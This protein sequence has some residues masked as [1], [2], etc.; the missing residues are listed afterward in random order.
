M[1]EQR[2][3]RGNR[4]NG[5]V[6]SVKPALI[7]LAC[8][9]IFGIGIGVALFGGVKDNQQLMSQNVTKADATV[10]T[11]EVDTTG[12]VSGQ[13][14]GISGQ[15][16]VNNTLVLN[17]S[18]QPT[19][20]V[21][22]QIYYDESANEVRYYD[23]TSFQGLAT[24]GDLAEALSQQ[25]AVQNR[26]QTVTNLTQQFL[27]QQTIN[28]YGAA[29][30]A[31]IQTDN[32][33]F[34]GTNTFTGANT[35]ADVSVQGFSASGAAS[36][37]GSLSVTGS[38]VLGATNAS[39]LLLSSALGVSSGGT[40]RSSFNA[41]EIVIGQGSGALST[42][43]NGVPGLCLI[44]TAGAPSFQTC[45]GGAGSAGVGSLNG[46]TGDLTI[47]NSSV[48]GSTI[49]I[50]SATTTS[51]GLASFNATNLSVT[52]GNV[53]TIQDIAVSA[54]PTFG[55]LT[56]NGTINGQSISS[57]ANFTGTLSVAGVITANTITPNG[58][59]VIGS[60]GQS[61]TLQGSAGTSLSATSG[62]N[63]TTL[64]FASPTA[65]VTYRLQSAAA[66]TYNVC[67]SAGNCVGLGGGVTTSGGTAGA[68]ARF[69]GSQ[70]LVDSI[71]SESGSTITVN[72]SLAVN[73]ITPTAALTVG[74]AV[75]SLVLQGDSSTR[76]T[77]QLGGITNSLL[78]SAPSGSNKSIVLPNA[79]GTVAVSASGPL[80][81]DA[82]GNISCATCTT[83]GGGAGGAV[84]SINGINGAVL[85]N[86]SSVA[87]STITI[88]DA[89]T[90]T[91]G[92]AS[93]NS[94]NFSVANGAVNTIQD[95]GVSST[96]TFNALTLNTPLGISSG[97]TGASTAAG[98]RTNLGA[99]ASG[100]NTDITSLGGLSTALS[101]SQGGT[102]ATSSQSAING[103]SQLTTQGDLLF[104]DGSNST[105][106]ARGSSGQCLT[107]STNSIAWSSCGP[108]EADTLATVTARGATTNTALF[109]QG[110]AT[111]RGLTIDTSSSTDD[112]I[113]LSVTSGG[114]S[115]FT[116]QIT[117][118]DLTA[119]RTWTLPDA[120]GTICLQGSSSCGFLT[121]S[122]SNYIQNQNASQ[123]AT[124]D[125]WISGTGRADIA[126]QAPSFDTATSTALN[127]GS[128]NASVLNL[129]QNTV[130]AASKS[131]TI[132]GGATGTRPAAPSEGM[133]YYDM[134]TKQLLVY[135]NGKWQ[136]DRTDSSVIVAANDS[137]NKEGADF[138]VSSADETAGN[139][140]ATITTAIASLPTSGGT[141]YLMEGTYTV[142]SGILLPSKT[143][144]A[145]AGSNSTIIKLKNAHNGTINVIDSNSSTKSNIKVQDLR[146]DGN[147]ANQTAGTQSGIYVS[148]VGDGTGASATA[149]MVIR[150]VDIIN[151]R[152]YGLDVYDSENGR[153]ENVRAMGN[154]S[155]GVYIHW[156][157]F[158]NVFTG[159]E[160]SGNGA[161]GFRLDGGRYNK[162]TSSK[163][164]SNGTGGARVE[165]TNTSE[166]SFEGNTAQ[167]NTG[168]GFDI[169]YG[170][171]GTYANN[172]IS[173]NSSGG[174]RL[175]MGIN[176][177]YTGALIAD[178]TIFSNTG[179]GIEADRDVANATISGNRLYSNTGYGISLAGYL[180]VENP[181]NNAI[182]GNYVYSNALGGINLDQ[183]DDTVVEGNN[184][185]EN[186]G[187]TTNNGIRLVGSNSSNNSINDNVITDASCT[188]N[189]YA[190]LV[191]SAANTTLSN[192]TLGNGTISD[193]GVG[194][195]YVNQTDASGNLI[196]RGKSALAVNTSTVS[197]SFT[198][199]GGMT[200]VQL[201]TPA[202]PSVSRVGTS[203]TSTYGY[204][205][206]AL[207]GT[208][209]T[210]ASTET[211]ITNGNA[212][213][214][215]TNYNSI[216]WTAVPGAVQYR[217]YRTTTNGTPATTGLIATTT[218]GNVTSLN[219]TGLAATTA[220]PTANTTGGLNV[221]SNIQGQNATL[222]G[223]TLTMG[224]TSQAGSLVISDGSSNTATIQV[225]NLAGNYTYSL[226]VVTANDTFCMLLAANCSG[227]GVTTVGA[228]DGG[229]ANANGATISSSTI[230]L[231]SA[232][233]T[234]PGLVNTTTQTFAGDKTFSGILSVQDLTVGAGKSITV[235][236]GITGTR[237]GTPV[238]GMVYFDTTTKQLLTYSNGKWQASRSSST[239]VVAASNSSQAAKD[240]AD[241]VATGTADQT[242]INSALTAAAGGTVL[243]MPGT[244]YQ[245]G[246]VSV[247]NNTI[248]S[249]SGMNT[250]L[251]MANAT[252]GIFSMIVN[253]DT[254]TGTNV[255]VRDLQIDGNRA[256][257][258]SGSNNGINFS[259]MGAG[260]GAAARPG[261]KITNVIVKNMRQD[262]GIIIGGSNNIVSGST[263][264]NNEI[265]G[266][267][268]AGSYNVVTGNT[269]HGN[270]N[271][272][273]TMTGS[274]NTVSNNAVENGGSY[275]IQ[276]VATYSTISG[277]TLNANGSA[278]IYVAG[279]H[280]T[281]TGNTSST[282]GIGIQVVADYATL[283]GNTVSG[284]TGNGI[285]VQANQAVIS[286]NNVDNN[287]QA[288]IMLYDDYS[289]VASNR[290]HNNGG[291]G[292]YC[293]ATCNYNSIVGNYITDTAG[294]SYAIELRSFSGTPVGNYLSNNQFS[295]NGAS[296]ISDE[297][298]DTVYSNQ[299]DG[300]GNTINRT[301]GG[302]LTI[303]TATASAS[304]TLQGGMVSGQ[305]TAPT[306]SATVTNVGTAGTTTYRYQVTAIDG[307]GE[308]VGSTI[309]QT[310]TG[311]AT[312]TTSNYNTI[313]WTAVP[314]AV[315]YGIYK[316]SGAACT[317]LKKT[318]V[319]G[320]ATSFNDQSAG[321]PVGAAPVS[322][323]T[324][325]ITIAG[326][327]QGSSA[328]L[329]GGLSVAGA[330]TL[331][332][333]LTAS[334]TALFKNAS[335]SNNAFQIQNSSSVALF[336]ADTSATKIVIRT[337]DISYNLTV[338]GHIITGGSTPTIAANAAACTS[339]TVSVS[340]TDTAGSITVT[341]GTGCAGGG[342]LATVTFAGAFG[343]TPKI[344][345][346][347]ASAAAAGLN[348]YQDDASLTTG[349]FSV[350]VVGTPADTTTYK[351]HYYALQ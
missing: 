143:I 74:S 15:L 3:E 240:A 301:P 57:N 322:N 59:M 273:I 289:Q 338:N 102:G 172:Y 189:C 69:N 26:P 150:D 19:Q 54:A 4:L 314:G 152:T 10:K 312:L 233:G 202:A 177:S 2:S 341:T 49:T 149:G 196:N 62:A 350:G 162:V 64:D 311:N 346:T 155:S 56:V 297:G 278:N 48:L 99:A 256:N 120:S 302:G 17:P 190:I 166:N 267:N 27:T 116:G 239:K 148:R 179:H 22:G 142:D 86:N 291:N 328:S 78:F 335:D 176:P 147:K 98:A 331:S 276:M 133:V 211:T 332:G 264:I 229:T 151:F 275:G 185:A 206:S 306:L 174:I 228:L 305:L 131:L 165:A 5:Q 104:H 108:G 349:A 221:V 159:I 288:G 138:V 128:T 38:S 164:N 135:A 103:L 226:P 76:L 237:P 21:A 153:Y 40:G 266:L 111:S 46:Q 212:T 234:S 89:S 325:G 262:R 298:T 75:Q 247:P 158:H 281:V 118:T 115:R 318:T 235:T 242:Q 283:T 9:G 308:T 184:V 144:L 250:V 220:V 257:Q 249:G 225:G 127:I 198:L 18:G 33:T 304:L 219:D 195:M 117:A 272:T 61:L 321:T 279:V 28:N 94:S 284:N 223:G 181:D 180:S 154:T 323:T 122:A 146:V 244:Y 282:S 7:S 13:S 263:I 207:D 20:T 73:T 171:A 337:L 91:K 238:E 227:G 43:A 252:N 29:E 343:A 137:R 85:L 245:T 270:Q 58:S 222:T 324:G 163:F 11:F 232:S 97:G 12:I 236:G 213:L 255:A 119:N 114:A 200:N 299:K 140:D 121:G 201:P 90:S 261:S 194:T 329:T 277:N 203:G 42:I 70:S 345:L 300:S 251:T 214:S 173:S 265:Q 106:L 259:N 342:Q 210:L 81:I 41:N 145:G 83:S 82:N 294:S 307:T 52:N 192:N 327:I 216:T 47:A 285:Q 334:S 36:L 347:P 197:S 175:E 161:F 100:A 71:L 248:L 186:G 124:S 254:S 340:G 269:F 280:A 296:T 309:Q 243:L 271:Y 45:P 24:N 218:G 348:A 25:P 292:I 231:Q 80:T 313:T 167:S 333:T 293:F 208:G 295:G 14:I 268:M 156:D 96:P 170:L 336:T 125:F 160:A 290:V 316:C 50:D 241:Y 126:L 123:Q 205:V 112:L 230:Y 37:Q 344:V 260:N 139:A 93:F 168:Y 319:S 157:V 101:I 113:T 286:G 30:D 204:R 35:F 88:N 141:V 169:R 129:N 224:T 132:T 95:I 182:T 136:A 134:T 193:T 107:S 67:T 339:P 310:T 178:N 79:S 65:N 63:K 16:R 87:G 351:W 92:I 60:N 1:R 217:V 84:D 320:S 274:Y 66:G 34:T 109:L 330:T 183:V 199:Q 246:A 6:G 130:I 23:G 253:S 326:A 31:A 72:G 188:T 209:E 53:N 8:F 317:P 51:R 68:L 187:T 258:T 55:G 287:S 32:N 77:A 110:G 215:V 105:R 303:G 44:S 191:S 315:Q 39:S